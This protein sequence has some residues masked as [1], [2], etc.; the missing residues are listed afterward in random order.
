MEY[1]L[2]WGTIKKS[3]FN[4]QIDRQPHPGTCPRCGSSVR[5]VLP[6]PFYG[7][8]GI[9][10][11]CPRCGRSSSVCTVRA[12]YHIEGGGIGQP[13]NAASLWQGLHMACEDFKIPQVVPVPD[14]S[15]TDK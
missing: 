8:Q 9:R 7:Q 5:A 6:F 3:T 15:K 2:D 12:T 4:R 13:I 1:K 10:I 11:E 14:W